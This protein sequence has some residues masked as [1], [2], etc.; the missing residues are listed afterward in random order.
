[1]LSKHAFK[2]EVEIIINVFETFTPYTPTLIKT[3]KFHK[4]KTKTIH[5]YSKV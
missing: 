3:K 5:K 4:K 1:M 2:L